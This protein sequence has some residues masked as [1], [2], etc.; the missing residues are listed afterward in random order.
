LIA[1]HGSPQLKEPEKWSNTFKDFMQRCLEVDVNNRASADELLKV[2]RL[3]ILARRRNQ[4][5]NMI[6]LI[7]SC[8]LQH[9]FLR[10][11]CPLKN[12]VP[13]IAKAKEVT[14]SLYAVATTQS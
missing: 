9:Q 5:R 4:G 10:M 1:T 7:L 11:A 8:G 6:L 13:L 2:Q 14:Q 12:L 3:I